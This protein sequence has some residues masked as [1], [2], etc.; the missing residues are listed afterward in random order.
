MV[1]AHFIKNLSEYTLLIS[2]I[3][4]SCIR[5]GMDKYEKLLFRGHSD[6]KY[7][8][9]PSLGRGRSMSMDISIFNEERNLIELAKYKLPD[10]FMEN[11]NPLE[12]LAL[13]Q[14]YGIPTRLLDVTESALVALYFSCCSNNDQTGEVIVFKTNETDVAN[15]PVIQAIADS[16]RFARGTFCPLSL[17]YGAVKTQPYF[18]EQ[19]QA[20]EI[21]RE[22]DEDGGEW[23]AECCSTPF[24]VYAP[25]R[26]AR[27]Q[28]QRGRYILFNNRV[29]ENIYTREDGNKSK[30]FATLIDP[31]LKDADCV[32]N[33]ISIPAEC[34]Q[35][36]LTELA[37]MGI[38]E[39]TLFPD[40]IDVVCRS[41]V[42]ECNA[43][44]KGKV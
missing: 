2:E 38:S 9:I 21:V 7:Q 43:R 10:I 14:H 33:I 27:Q 32:A 6:Q 34:K 42:D 37:V 5:N 15:Y 30:H 44:W 18:L 16:Y 22:T 26:S 29:E 31:I 11:L 25:I 20:N 13:M 8:I 24:F 40:N 35:Q 4:S 1:N 17:F 36:L 23:I 41:I 12:L 28:A 39:E 3:G 19:K